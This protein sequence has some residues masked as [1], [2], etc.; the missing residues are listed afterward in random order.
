M[1]GSGEAIEMAVRLKPDLVILDINMPVLGG[2]AT[3]IEIK[4]LLR[5]EVAFRSLS[6]SSAVL[7]SK[8]LARRHRE[9]NNLAIDDCSVR[10]FTQRFNH[11]LDKSSLRFGERA[12]RIGGHWSRIIAGQARLAN[13]IKGWL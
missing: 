12:Q 3:A 10:H 7:T 8:R 11:R 2:F 5:P 6:F 9:R 4:R 13:P 1:R